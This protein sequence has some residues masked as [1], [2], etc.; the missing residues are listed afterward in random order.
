MIEISIPIHINF[1]TDGELTIVNLSEKI[2]DLELEKLVLN[3]F[4][5][6]FNEIITTELCG[7]KY[8]HD[9]KEKRY[10]RAGKSDRKI[11]TLLG[12]LDLKIDKIRNKLTGEIFKPI[13][14]ILGIKPYKNYQD[15]IIFTSADIA[16]K[17]TYRDTVYIMENFLK[18][19]L[20]PSTINRQLIKL[21][22]EIKEFMK[23]KNKDNEDTYDHLYGDGTKSHS[24]EEV[25]KNDI[26]VAITTNKKGEKV[27]LSCNVN[28]TWDE[29]N[30][31]IEELDVLSH[32]AVLVSDAEPGLKKAL[33]S[34]ER[35]YQ[36]DFIHFIRDIGYKLWS[37]NK[38]N[39]D[40]RKNIKKTCRRNH[41]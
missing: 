9:K 23:N 36:L 4:I 19:I 32:D 28:K 24:Q 17:S 7:E 26:K 37:D 34:A 13:L 1:T 39:L 20:S 16:T 8:K 11:I 18:K 2:Q 25:Y 3:Q 21:G 10:E 6:K 22:K 41:L 15:D 38:L 12:E 5:E 30:Q 35:K 27:F 33:A 14:P 29:L 40:T 31:E